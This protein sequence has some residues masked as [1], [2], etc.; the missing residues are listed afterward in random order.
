MKISYKH[1]SIRLTGRWEKGETCATTTA[2][3]SYFE[4][5][6][7]GKNATIIFDT[8]GC[9]NPLPHL[10]IQLDS[11]AM[12]ETAVDAYLRIRASD[13]TEHICKVIMKSS[14][15][16]FNRW[17]SPLESKISFVGIDTDEPLPIGEDTRKII[18]FVGDS[19]TE[20]VL[21]N[22]D[23]FGD[24]GDE[25][26]SVGILNRVFQDDSTS[27]YAFLT[28]EKLN[29]RPVFMGYGAVG[30]TKSGQGKVP[31]ASVSYPYNFDGS[32][33]TRENPDFILI[34]HGANDRGNGVKMYLEDYEALLNVIIKMNPSAKIISLSAFCGAFHTELKEFINTYNEKHNTNIFFIDSFGW[35]PE[36][37]LHPLTDGHKIIAEKLCEELKTVI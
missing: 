20:G 9:P 18:E 36:E 4:F 12:V 33:I 22:A 27:T 16:E 30:V 11:G 25:R 28:A 26:Y 19:I 24:G 17:F 14:V 31:K 23:Y 10:F 35:V 15:E 5:K 34:N 8:V 13:D 3:G 7:K 29:L 2:N 6:F 1:N 32:P 37:P 21:V